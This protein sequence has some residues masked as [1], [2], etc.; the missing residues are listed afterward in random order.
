MCV[1]VIKCVYLKYI[2]DI[3][4]Q[5]IY[6][7]SIYIYIQYVYIYTVYNS[8]VPTPPTAQSSLPQLLTQTAADV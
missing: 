4:I 2:Y 8:Q 3:Y 1:N 7:Y 6:I 5:Y